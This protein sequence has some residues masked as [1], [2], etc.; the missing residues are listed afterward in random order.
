MTSS[1]TAVTY[2]NFAQDFFDTWCQSCHAANQTNRNGAPDDIF[3]DTRDDIYRLRSQ[4]YAQAAGTNSS[5]P[6]GAH[7][8]SD[9]DR[10]KLADWLA[11]GAP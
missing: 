10:E 5:M 6:I 1:T 4:V 9:S 8:P 3:F 11:C 7:G 2:D